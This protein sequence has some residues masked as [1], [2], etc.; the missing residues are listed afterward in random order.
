MLKAGHPSRSHGSAGFTLIELLIAMILVLVLMAAFT[1]FLLGA[2]SNSQK[3]NDESSAIQQVTQS[4]TMFSSDLQ[5]AKSPDR[6]ETQ[7]G[8]PGL[9]SDALLNGV[10][11][12]NVV[13]NSTITLDVADIVAAT[14]TSFTFRS[15]VLARPGVE[16]V[17]Y[18]VTPGATQSLMR[19]V[20]PY[21]SVTHTCDFATQLV[22]DQLIQQ[23]R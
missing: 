17:T 14:A 22:Q 12:K 21:N 13:N 1:S 5:K 2:F 19:Q 4:I 9:L 11:L 16:C 10:P 20:N 23:V 7:L 15:D 3:A 6:E 18:S 8:D